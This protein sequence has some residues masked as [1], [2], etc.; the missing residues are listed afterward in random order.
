MKTILILSPVFSPNIGGVETHL[1]DLVTALDRRGYD[2]Y[3]LTYSPITSPGVRWQFKEKWGRN[4]TIYRFGW[5]G[6]NLFHRL[7]RYPLLDFLYLAPYLGLISFFFLLF[8]C[9]RVNVIHA[10]GLNAA[11]IGS[12]L[13]KVFRKKLVV[14]T[15]AVYEIGKN[16]RTATRIKNILG[17]ADEI[18][19]LSRASLEELASFSIGP[20][21]LDLYSYWINLDSFRPAQKPAAGFPPDSSWTFTVLFVGRL[22]KKKGAGIL[23]EV[24]KSLPYI[25]FIFIGI[26]PEEPMLKEMSQRYKN[27]VF[28]GKVPNKELPEYYN[29][30]D[31][32]C[33]PSQYEEGFGRV[34]MEAVACGVPVIGSNKGGIPEALDETV[35]ILTEPTAENLSKKILQLYHDRNAYYMMKENCRTYALG[36]FSEE[37]VAHITSHY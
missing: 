2:V 1:D 27:I 11:L 14:S 21:K 20:E 31:I 32:F 15:H 13:K 3:V 6:K 18:L 4:I 34:V 35:S 33:I 26:G 36:H 9:R 25:Q 16:S 24:A 17:S 10:Q 12:V 8:H 5:I 23:L 29:R 30:A 19:C 22:I 7:E 37:N 28:V